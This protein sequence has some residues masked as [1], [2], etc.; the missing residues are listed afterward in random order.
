MPKRFLSV[1]VVGWV[2]TNEPTANAAGRSNPTRSVWCERVDVVLRLVVTLATW[3]QLIDQFRFM[4]PANVTASGGT[5]PTWTVRQIRP[6]DGQTKETP[7]LD[8]SAITS[9][10]VIVPIAI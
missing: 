4:T 9:V 3:G 6:G 8:K 5:S 7:V 10:A 1:V 2:I